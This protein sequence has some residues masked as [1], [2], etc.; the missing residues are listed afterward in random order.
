M[1]AYFRH[2]YHEL[3]KDRRIFFPDFPYDMVTTGYIRDY[4][5]TLLLQDCYQGDLFKPKGDL[6]K[7]LKKNW[8]K[9]MYHE[10]LR[11]TYKNKNF[12]L[13]SVVAALCNCLLRRID[14]VPVINPNLTIVYTKEVISRLN[15]AIDIMGVIILNEYHMH[16][17]IREDLLQTH[18]DII[19]CSDSFKTLQ[20]YLDDEFWFSLFGS[21]MSSSTGFGENYTK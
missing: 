5:E 3:V 21:V 15:Y 20:E 19:D 11:L 8:V 17:W 14:N 12:T 7:C 2:S 1:A 6:I 9:F 10:V 13:A 4:D 16:D 18:K